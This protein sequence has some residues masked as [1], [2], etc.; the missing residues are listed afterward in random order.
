MNYLGFGKA[1]ELA[2]ANFGKLKEHKAMFCWDV[3]DPE[4]KKMVTGEGILFEDLAHDIRKQHI[5][6]FVKDFAQASIDEV[7]SLGLR[8]PPE[9]NK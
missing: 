8:I 2:N 6:N 5:E 7:F 4:T 1:K 3:Y 9:W